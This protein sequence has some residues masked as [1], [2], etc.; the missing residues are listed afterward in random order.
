M[1]S[2]KSPPMSGN[3][4]Y[5]CGGKC[6]ELVGIWFT[7]LGKNG[8]NGGRINIFEGKV[9]RIRGKMVHFPGEE[10]TRNEHS[11]YG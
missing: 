8:E 9:P 7:F 2:P 4:N 11:G 6:L 10:Q 1:F 3:C 5:N